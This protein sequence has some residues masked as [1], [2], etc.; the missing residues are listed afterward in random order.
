MFLIPP[1]NYIETLKKLYQKYGKA[2]I[3]SLK[4]F[5]RLA[6]AEAKKVSQMLGK[7]QKDKRMEVIL[8]KDIVVKVL[9]ST[10]TSINSLFIR[11]NHNYRNERRNVYE[12]N[13]EYMN[14][15]KKYEE[16]KLKLF[17]YTL[18][19]VCEEVKISFAS[20]QKSVFYYLDQKESDVT[21]LIDKSSSIGKHFAIAPRNIQLEEVIEILEKYYENM[22]YI[23]CSSNTNLI[24]YA[25]ILISDVIYEYYGIEEEQVFLLLN[26]RE[27]IKNNLKVVSILNK[28]ALLVGKNIDKIYEI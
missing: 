7:I 13:S 4:E 25:N 19:K 22:N 1:E 11:I 23:V 26:E 20:L 2:R 10:Y 9:Q 21:I 27:D 15:I 28:I 5:K 17:K 16:N 3:R 6:I 12:N 18:R 24:K 14:I 8:S